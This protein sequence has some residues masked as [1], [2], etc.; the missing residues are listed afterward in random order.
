[1]TV[2]RIPAPFRGF[3][4]VV[5]GQ[6]RKVG[7]SS[8]VADIIRTFP[9]RH[10]IAAKI[11]PHAD[12]GCPVEGSSCNC[13]PEEHSYAI[14]KET[15]RTD[16]SDSSRFLAAGAHR[17]LWVE[18]KEHGLEDALPALVAELASAESEYAVIES[19]ALMR[20]WKPSLSIMVL[21]PSNPDFKDSAR[22]NLPRADAFV[23]RSPFNDSDPRFRSFAAAPKPRFFQPIGSP[24]PPDL[25]HFLSGTISPLPA[26]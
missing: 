18:T 12:P 17:S 21:D 25:G 2:S 5:G 19:D 9:D 6:R 14:H 23:F 4:L 24:L 26:S 7:K 10:W 11:T 1:M 22:E 3:L 20:F 15:S 16:N 13:R 8:L